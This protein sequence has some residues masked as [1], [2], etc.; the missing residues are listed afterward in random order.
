MKKLVF[1]LAVIIVSTAVFA[2]GNIN[3]A[4]IMLGGIAGFDSKKYSDGDES[5]TTITFSPN[6]GYFFMNQFAGGLRFN[7]LSEKYSE[8]DDASSQFELAPFVRYYF[9]PS[10]NKTNFFLDGSYGFGSVSEGGE[11]ASYNSFSFMGGPSFFLTPSA[12]LEF[13]IG[14]TS[15]GGEEVFGPDIRLNTFAIKV[16]FQVH[17]GGSGAK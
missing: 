15:M 7:F 5:L 14:Y 8:D 1:L 13:G 10:S 4:N 12:A 3:K 9:L 16:G 6:V 11:S 2:Q 17:L